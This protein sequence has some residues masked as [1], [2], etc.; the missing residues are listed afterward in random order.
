MTAFTTTSAGD[1]WG[2][3]PPLR[4]RPFAAFKA[5]FLDLYAPPL[6]ARA[7]LVKM[8]QMMAA[9][10]ELLA[11]GATT[12][13]LTP[14]FV[15]RFLASLPAGNA[16]ITKHGMLRNLRAACNYAVTMRYLAVSPFAFRKSRDWVRPGRA[17]E[18]KH[19]PLAAIGRVLDLARAD[20]ARL[21]D[22]SWDQWR[23]RRLLAIASVVAYTGLR[24]REALFLRVED[25]DLAGR[26]I[27]LTPR[28]DNRLKTE[29]SAQ[30]IPMPEALAGVLAEWLPHLALPACA[31]PLPGP[32]GADRRDA[33]WV[34]PN[35]H[36]TGPW[37]HGAP[38]TRP[39]DHLVALGE[40]AGVEG[41]TFISLRHSWA[42]HAESA[43]G[44]SEAMIR[45]VLRHTS[46]K[47][48]LGYRHAD[49]VNLSSAVEG[50]RFGRAP[51]P[52]APAREAAAD[53]GLADPAEIAGRVDAARAGELAPAPPRV[54]PAFPRPNPGGPRKLT[55][56]VRLELRRRFAG[57]ETY[58]QLVARTCLSR[59]SIYRAIHGI[60]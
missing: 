43:W 41:F 51:L 53:P 26:I 40:R 23:A 11:P 15:G 24:K 22:G 13:D 59:N 45:R 4:P 14:A 25:L 5:E 21:P 6:R 33:A 50:I 34:F 16:G 37:I 35:A 58:E 36:R 9:V 8:R 31:P 48:Q 18:K 52:P 2:A 27:A 44:F 28:S 49:A 29:A 38:G 39:L 10:E 7:T 57:G 3:I 56:E 60:D 1:E 17:A 46:T 42:T 54:I 55:P 12:G 20:V 32:S 47:T 19:H 30:P